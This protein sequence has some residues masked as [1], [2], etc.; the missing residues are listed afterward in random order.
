MGAY[1]FAGCGVLE[2]VILPNGVET[3]GECC[4]MN[5]R[6]LK[7]IWIPN[8]IT[9]IDKQSFQDCIKLESVHLSCPKPL[10][11]SDNVFGGIDIGKVTL[12]IPRGSLEQYKHAS[13]WGMFG[14]IMEE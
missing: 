11:I 10:E 9:L 13:V 4:F 6:M 1:S 12:Y 2:S 3:L 14:N 7:S 8:T 5:N